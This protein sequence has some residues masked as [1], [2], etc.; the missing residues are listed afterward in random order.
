LSY[1]YPPS[2][3]LRPSGRSGPY[4]RRNAGA[5]GIRGLNRRL[6]LIGRGLHLSGL[7][8]LLRHNLPGR[9]R[10][11]SR[12]NGHLSRLHGCRWQALGTLRHI[13]SHLRYWSSR[14]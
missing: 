10:C 6:H 12:L 1:S 9:N 3:S 13:I 5:R 4:R 8:R 11:L 7:I 14:R 2:D